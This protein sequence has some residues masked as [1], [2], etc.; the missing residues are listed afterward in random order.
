MQ[1]PSAEAKNGLCM[2]VAISTTRN[3]V[4]GGVAMGHAVVLDY[5]L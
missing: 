2:V 3:A 1:A 4:A 5:C